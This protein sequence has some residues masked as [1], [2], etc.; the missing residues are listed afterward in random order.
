MT[1]TVSAQLTASIMHYDVLPEARMGGWGVRLL[2][3]FE[4]WAKNR[5]V[6]EISFGINSG[7][8]HGSVGRFAGKMGF[9][10]V[11]ENFVKGLV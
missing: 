5:Q 8:G 1:I 2:R 9:E 7:D 6:V 4:L 3:A 10:K 11:G